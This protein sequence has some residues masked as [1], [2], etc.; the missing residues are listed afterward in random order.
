MSSNEPIKFADPTPLG[1]LAFGMTTVL[2][3]LHNAGFFPN[4]SVVLA[5]GIFIGGVAQ[6][7]AGLMEYPRGNTFGTVAFV[8]YGCFWLSLVAIWVLPVL[9]WTEAPSA[10]FVGAYLALW[11]LYTFFMLLGTLP[12][13]KLLQFVFLTLLA[14][15]W[16]LALSCFLGSAAIGVLA[17]WVGLVCGFSA[18]YLAV[19]LV[20]MEQHG[21]KYLPFC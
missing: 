13:P 8:S 21:R 1:L 17:G 14:L 10:G 6:T 9:G 5:M 19:A 18:I 16:L 15:F 11:G 7:I 2:L 3:N 20:L 4:T 12:G